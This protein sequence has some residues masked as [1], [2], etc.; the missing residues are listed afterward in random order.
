MKLSGPSPLIVIMGGTEKREGCQK[1]KFSQGK[2]I[3]ETGSVTI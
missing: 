1:L 3:T 2:S